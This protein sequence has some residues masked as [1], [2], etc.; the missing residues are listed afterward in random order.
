MSFLMDSK[1]ENSQMGKIKQAASI[2]DRDIV[3]GCPKDSAKATR[4]SFLRSPVRC[5]Y[6]VGWV[7]AEGGSLDVDPLSD[8]PWTASP[9]PL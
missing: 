1:Q 5:L 3:P 9:L 8:L 7:L 4:A 6:K 2:I